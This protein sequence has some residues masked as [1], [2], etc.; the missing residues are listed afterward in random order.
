[1][2]GDTTRAGWHAAGQY[3]ADHKQLMGEPISASAELLVRDVLVLGKRG[4]VD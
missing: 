1:M 2:L 3:F 4:E